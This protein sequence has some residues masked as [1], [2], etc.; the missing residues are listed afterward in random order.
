MSGSAGNPHLCFVSTGYRHGK[1]HPVAK[2]SGNK[3][4]PRTSPTVYSTFRDPGR[5]LMTAKPSPN[6]RKWASPRLSGSRVKTKEPENSEKE[7]LVISPGYIMKRSKSHIDVTLEEEFFRNAQDNPPSTPPSRT[8]VKTWRPTTTQ[9][10]EKRE[11]SPMVRESIVEDL[12]EQIAT[13]TTLLDQEI[14]DHQKTQK[15]LT[16]EMEYRITDL[17]NKN[18]E[19][20]RNL[21]EK[22]AEE[23]LVLQQQSNTKLLQEK[24]EVE[25]KY[26]ELQKDIDLLKGSFRTYQESLTEEMNAEWLE[27]EA[28]WK[29]TFE[30]EKMNEMRKQKQTLTD[31]FEGQKRELQ[32]RALEESSTVQRSFEKQMEE[33]WTKYKEALQEAKKQDMLKT[34]NQLDDMRR[35]LD[36]R[37]NKVE[38]K[39]SHRIHSLL[40]ENADLRRKLITKHEQ[41]F[42]ERNKQITE[43]EGEG[44]LWD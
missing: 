29:E 6:V 33:T 32:K 9:K 31:A 14:T 28:K 38:A 2:S 27:K 18:E 24:V 42:N 37:V 3:N 36:S 44:N 43:N 26:E 15:R 12:Q 13:L 39:Y 11:K 7:Y 1:Q 22:H 17:L 41:L 21:Q 19:E 20:M 5:D 4:R 30:N 8:N 16:L 34:K 23:R 40:N 35:S 10:P 25:K